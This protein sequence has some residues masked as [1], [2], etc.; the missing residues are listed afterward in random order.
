MD[1][2]LGKPKP[3]VA[4]PDPRNQPGQVDPSPGEDLTEEEFQT[5]VLE[6][7]R[8]EVQPLREQ[9]NQLQAFIDGMKVHG[10]GATPKEVTAREKMLSALV[11]IGVVKTTE[12]LMMAGGVKEARTNEILNEELEKEHIGRVGKNKWVGLAKDE[13]TSDN[14]QPEK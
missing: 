12:E 1:W 10:N 7:V 14:T 8:K 4:S 5:M 11:P 2:L 6:L 3:R 13:N 9:V